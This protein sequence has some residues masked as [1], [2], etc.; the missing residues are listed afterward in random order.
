[1]LRRPMPATHDG[2]TLALKYEDWNRFFGTRVK[3]MLVPAFIVWRPLNHDRSLTKF[4]VGVCR[5]LVKVRPSASPAPSNGEMNRKVTKFPFVTPAL[6]S[7]IFVK[8][9]RKLLVIVGDN[10]ASWPSAPP[11]LL[12]RRCRR[13]G[14]PG[15]CG[16]LLMVSS[17]LPTRA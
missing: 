8:P 16:V 1:M 6:F 5:V 17:C 11:Q 4:C 12:N 14:K 3:R 2:L 9:Y 7:S 15:N 10:T 13:G